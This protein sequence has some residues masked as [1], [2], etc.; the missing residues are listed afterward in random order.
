ML[1]NKSATCTE[2]ERCRIQDQGVTSSQV[3]KLFF[4]STKPVSSC[5]S[6]PANPTPAASKIAWVGLSV[7]TP[8]ADEAVSI[9]EASEIKAR[10][11]VDDV[12]PTTFEGAIAA[13]KF[14][15][16]YT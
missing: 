9:A 10:E 13:L 7:I 3:T 12:N 5:Q 2:I 8:V 1:D 11:K 14:T 4:A 15:R 16:K 6:Q